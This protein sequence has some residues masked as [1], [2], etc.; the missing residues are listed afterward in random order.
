MAS[1]ASINKARVKIL[2]AASDFE[3]AFPNEKSH[4]LKE[5]ARHAGYSSIEGKAFRGAIKDLKSEGI[6]NGSKDVIAITD[7]GASVLPKAKSKPSENDF[8]EQFLQMLCKNPKNLTGGLPTEAKIKAVF[9]TLLDGKEHTKQELAKVAGY[10][11]IDSK[12]FRNLMT[13]FVEVKLV[14]NTK[15]KTMELNDTAFGRAGR[16]SNGASKDGKE[17]AVNEEDIKEPPMKKVKTNSASNTKTSPKNV[18]KKKDGVFNKEDEEKEVPGIIESESKSGTKTKA[19]SKKEKAP[20]KKSGETA[21]GTNKSNESPEK[22]EN[23]VTDAAKDDLDVAKNEEEQDDEDG[24]YESMSSSE[25][26][27]DDGSDWEE[28]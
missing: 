8:Q 2:Q 5:I 24:L 17:K 13:R 9:K 22:E 10:N 7:K 27:N 14:D 4:D 20:E 15:G 12:K 18:P 21:E 28:E 25:E 26:E 23:A 6:F 1:E 16:P 19:I 3:A 11:A